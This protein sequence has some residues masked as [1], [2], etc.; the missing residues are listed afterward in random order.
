MKYHFLIDLN[1]L[2]SYIANA[3]TF[4]KTEKIYEYA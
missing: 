1:G 4:A 3:E 2:I